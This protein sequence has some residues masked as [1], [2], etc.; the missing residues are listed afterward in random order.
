MEC[1]GRHQKWF[2]KQKMF[3]YNSPSPL[4]LPILIVQGTKRCFKELQQCKSTIM[5]NAGLQ[6][7]DGMNGS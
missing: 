4:K 1:R 5:N 3:E 2:S 6:V 7:L